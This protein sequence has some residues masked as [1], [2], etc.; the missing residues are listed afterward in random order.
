MKIHDTTD[1]LK[2]ICLVGAAIGLG[3]LLHYVAYLWGLT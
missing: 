2:L 3:F 1:V